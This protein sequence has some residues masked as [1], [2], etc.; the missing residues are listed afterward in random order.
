MICKSGCDVMWS[1]ERDD[2]K[3]CLDMVF[4]HKIRTLVCETNFYLWTIMLAK[5][6]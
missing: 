6:L 4:P 5:I 3:K 2:C 1:V